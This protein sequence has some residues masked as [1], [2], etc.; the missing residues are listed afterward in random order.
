VAK[1]NPPAA[2]KTIIIEPN[3][4]LANSWELFASEHIHNPFAADA[5][6]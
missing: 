3:R 2:E 4:I 5:R 6:F 1:P